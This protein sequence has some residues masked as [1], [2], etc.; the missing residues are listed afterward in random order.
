MLAQCEGKCTVAIININNG[1]KEPTHGYQNCHIS[2]L[3]IFCSGYV[4]VR[5]YVYIQVT[6]WVNTILTTLILGR[7]CL[8]M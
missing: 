6:T 5:E 3:L 8:G 4:T 1:T 7:F 2:Q